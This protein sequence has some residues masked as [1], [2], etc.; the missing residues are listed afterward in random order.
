MVYGVME[1]KQTRR[2]EFKS[3]SYIM[4]DGLSAS[5][6]CCQAQSGPCDQF[7]FYFFLIIFVQLVQNHKAE[8]DEMG[9][10]CGTNGGEEEHV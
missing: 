9:G 10:T 4:T 8:E 6:S 3:Q 1:V 7:F 2:W 5:L